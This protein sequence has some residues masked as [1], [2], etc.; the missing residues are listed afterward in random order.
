MA[1]PPN[2]APSGPLGRAAPP[3]AVGPVA[4][5]MA[6]DPF[7]AAL[8]A[9]PT[10]AAPPTAA[11]ASDASG[12]PFGALDQLPPRFGPD[13]DIAL[14]SAPPARPTTAAPTAPPLK[15]D[16]LPPPR[17]PTRAPPAPPAPPPAPASPPEP[18]S[19][20][21]RIALAALQAAVFVA[22]L[23]GSVG[24]ARSDDARAPG[25][26]VA[27]VRVA[28]RTTAGG[29]DVVVVSGFVD[30]RSG[31]DVAGVVVEARVG[32][33]AA[34]TV[35]RALPDPLAL[36]RAA[37]ANDITALGLTAPAD[38]RVA[39]GERAPFAIVVAAPRD[40]AVGT[41]SARASGAAP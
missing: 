2:R 34:R 9:A 13:D 27:D 24:A 39:A 14:L 11:R 41:L 37:S 19:R 18:T 3:D 15:R 33:I 22:A 30:N 4:S 21:V 17:A 31:H 5:S 10:L 7:A 29:V 38:T 20:A 25:V 40:A 8:S 26:D 1:D 36:Q 32:T 16:L 35:A 12:D 28:R 6:A 23:V